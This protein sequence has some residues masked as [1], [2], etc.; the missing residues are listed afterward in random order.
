VTSEANDTAVAAAKVGY[1][2]R[3]SAYRAN[4]EVPEPKATQ[5]HIPGDMFSRI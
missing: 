3:E 2:A 4:L 1:N 5:E